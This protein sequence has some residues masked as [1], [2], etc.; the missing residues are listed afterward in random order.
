MPLN[1]SALTGGPKF[2]WRLPKM[3]QDDFIKEFLETFSELC[4]TTR[5]EYPCWNDVNLFDPDSSEILEVHLKFISNLKIAIVLS[6][7][8]FYVSGALT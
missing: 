7:L 8:F 3:I 6:L 1:K 5:R 2:T 4:L